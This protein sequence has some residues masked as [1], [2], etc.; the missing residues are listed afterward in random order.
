MSSPMHAS[1]ALEV[2]PEDR[3]SGGTWMAWPT[4]ANEGVDLV[5]DTGFRSSMQTTNLT[6]QNDVFQIGYQSPRFGGF[7][8]V[9]GYSPTSAGGS[10]SGDPKN[11]PTDQDLDLMHDLISVGANFSESFNGVDVGV[12][13]GYEYGSVG[14]LITTDDQ[15]IFKVGASLGAS[16]FTIAGSYGV[17]DSDL[18]DEGIAWDVGVSYSTGPWGVSATYFHGE[19]EGS[20]PGSVSPLGVALDPTGQDDEVDAFVGA[21]SYSIGPGITGS[22]SIFHAKWEEEAGVI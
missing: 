8:F 16:G 3:G 4:R 21:V 11:A 7:Q 18:S 13:A 14:D 5:V 10:N 2:Q 20:T 17:Y 1:F 22:L 12:A 9:A 19:E 15:Q 6:L